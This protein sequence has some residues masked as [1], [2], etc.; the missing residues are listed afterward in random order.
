MGIDENE[1]IDWWTNSYLPMEDLVTQW[2]KH[3][4]SNSFQNVPQSYN[5]WV[6]IQREQLSTQ[7]PLL[8]V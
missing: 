8:N 3:T 4:K 5:L 6:P 1:K 2:N 7:M